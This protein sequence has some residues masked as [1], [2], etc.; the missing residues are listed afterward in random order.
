MHCAAWSYALSAALDRPNAYAPASAPVKTMGEEAEELLH[1][2]G[3]LTGKVRRALSTGAVGMVPGWRA[4]PVR[5]E[6]DG[7]PSPLTAKAAPRCSIIIPVFNNLELTR[8]CLD[9]IQKHTEPGSYEII[10]ADNG[11]TDGTGQFLQ[12][13]AAQGV[14]RP[15]FHGA[16]Q[17]FARASNQGARAAAGE[18][19]VFLNNDTLVT[20]GWLKELT[21]SAAQDDKIAAVG[22]KLLFPDDTVQHAGVAF[23][24]EKKVFHIYKYFHRD[25]PA[26]NKNR[27]FQALT[28]ACLLVK[29]EAFFEAGLFD[30]GFVNGFEDVDLCLNLGSR[31]WKLLYNPHS[32]VYH[33]ESKTPGRH[34]RERENALRLAARWFD[35][36][37]PDAESYHAAD[38][39][40]IHSIRL[41]TGELAAFM[42]DPSENPF[43]R[44]AVRLKQAGDLE[45]ALEQYLHAMRFN[46]FDSR[47]WLIGAELADLC[48][49]MGNPRE[50]ALHRRCLAPLLPAGLHLTE[51]SLLAADG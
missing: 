20:P 27:E 43:W 49:Q 14:V 29:R 42:Y 34:A 30:E 1:L 2:Y 25:H 4:S 22:A 41:A 5:E 28:A 45:R 32:V 50:A 51:E 9:S 39:I 18:Y 26:V 11:S 38:G 23:S 48:E 19:L 12:D 17:G 44:Q 6:P 3:S 8:N 13:K 21:G 37:R 10:V 35:R 46:P 7:A 16:N 40:A 31:G 36:I 47:K 24:A 15:I 33:L